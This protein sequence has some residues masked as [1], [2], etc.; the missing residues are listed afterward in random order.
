MHD[1]ALQESD[2]KIAEIPTR[3]EEIAS[4]ELAD[5]ECLYNRIQEDSLEMARLKS[6]VDVTCFTLG[7]Q[8]GL[9]AHT[10][11]FLMR[12]YSLATLELKRLLEDREV[13]RRR[14]EYL[15]GAQEAPD[16]D[17]YPDIEMSRARTQIDMLELSIR[18]KHAM[19]RAFEKYRRQLLEKNCGQFT[20][21]QYQD[22]E[23]KY[24]QLHFDNLSENYD[25]QRMLG[26]PEGL[27]NSLK[28]LQ[29]DNPLLGYSPAVPH[30][31]TSDV[32]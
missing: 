17:F 15:T 31:L 11:H 12:Q 14:I 2:L 13:Q 21:E 10:F 7:S 20:D 18:N 9:P 24:W 29:Q 25:Q 26:K 8:Y 5:I 27:L 32:E 23:P 1:I 3:T 16:K 4:I 28:L 22:E 30:L 19:C 6:D